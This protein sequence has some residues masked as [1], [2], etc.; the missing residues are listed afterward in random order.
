M[1]T[2]KELNVFKESLELAKMVYLKTSGFPKEEIY[3]LTNQIRRAVVSI[4]ANISEGA[5]RQNLKE[6]RH[7]RRIAF[8]SLSELET[9]LQLSFEFGFLNN[10]DFT[11]LYEKIKLMTVQLSRLIRSF[12]RTINRT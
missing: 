3:G 12:E 1:K 6:Y 2:H 11:L 8:G 7:F 10:F 9:L 5:G 4:P